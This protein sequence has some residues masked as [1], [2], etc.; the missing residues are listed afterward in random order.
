MPETNINRCRPVNAEVWS[1]HDRRS[2]P[3]VYV[4]ATLG[5]SKSGPYSCAWVRWLDY[6]F[7][8]SRN[9]SHPIASAQPVV[10]RLPSP[11]EH[12]CLE[13]YDRELDYL[14]ATLRR[15]GARGTEAEDL[16]QEVFIV[17]HKNW[18]TID[19]TR[20]LRPYLFGIAFRICAAHRRRNRREIPLES[21]EVSDDSANP[22]TAMQRTEATARLRA[23]LERLPLSRRAVV[24]MHDIDG[25]P[26]LEI[27][28]ALSMSRFGVYARLR[29][30][31]QE[32][33]AAVRRP[34]AGRPQLNPVT[35]S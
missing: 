19:T 31:R 8:P 24:V 7:C 20:P 16:A 33:R 14:L 2:D 13:A 34:V 5:S 6:C 3:D 4:S 23:A 29:K 17:L 30:G 18:P 22:E 15:L 1:P 9:V 27:A 11:A 32:L 35:G 26:V 25:V 10:A 12:A 28:Q 21:F